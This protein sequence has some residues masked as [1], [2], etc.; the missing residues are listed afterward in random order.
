MPD[1]RSVV[2]TADRRASGFH[3]HARFPLFC[4]A[5]TLSNPKPE[6]A[7]LCSFLARPPRIDIELDSHRR[8]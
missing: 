1:R 5:V 3:A 2:Q 8:I 6:R 7:K 4:V